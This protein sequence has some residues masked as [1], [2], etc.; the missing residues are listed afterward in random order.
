MNVGR[1]S[2]ETY[3]ACLGSVV[4]VVT[5]AM[6]GMF[7]DHWCWWIG[8]INHSNGEMSICTVELGARCN[9]FPQFHVWHHVMVESLLVS[10]IITGT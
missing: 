3:R 2:E 6:Y 1:I 9:G 5:D 8:G 7:I 4:D 10:L